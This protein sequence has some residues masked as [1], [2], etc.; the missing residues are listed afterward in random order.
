MWLTAHATAMS[1]T[2][3][4]VSATSVRKNHV[5][6]THYK[7]RSASLPPGKLAEVSVVV[8]VMATA[9]ATATHLGSGVPTVLGWAPAWDSVADAAE[10]PFLTSTF[11]VA[12][13]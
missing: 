3:I 13:G 11:C 2:A 9:M 8:A 4:R 10:I 7:L 6:L 12:A 1:H 5:N